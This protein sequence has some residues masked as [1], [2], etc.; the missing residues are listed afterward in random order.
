MEVVKLIAPTGIL[1][2]ALF[3]ISVVTGFKKVRLFRWHKPAGYLCGFVSVFHSYLAVS[4]HAID[5]VGILAA[6]L[7]IATVLSGIFIRRRKALHVT[8]T[9]ITLIFVAG[10]IALMK[11]LN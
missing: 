11:Y 6:L 4:R 8:L 1:A 7:M 10:H 2:G 3:I 5:P 9:V